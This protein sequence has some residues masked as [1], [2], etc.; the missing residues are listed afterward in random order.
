MIIN[1]EEVVHIVCENGSLKLDIGEDAA[2]VNTPASYNSW[3]TRLVIKRLDG[4]NSGPISALHVAGIFSEDGNYRLDIGTDAMKRDTPASFES[5]ATQL[6]IKRLDGPSSGPVSYGDLV[7][8]FDK[9]GNYRLDIGAV[10]DKAI[11]ASHDS[12]ATRLRIL[13]LPK[14][15]SQWMSQLPDETLLVNLAIP[16][17]H[18][19]AATRGWGK[20]LV[21]T[22]GKTQELPIG[23]Q[24]NMGIR[25]FDVRLATIDDKCVAIH[26]SGAVMRIIYGDAASVYRQSIMG[27]LDNNPGET[28]FICVKCEYGNTL[29]S[30]HLDSFLL[31]F[32]L[33]LNMTTSTTLAEVRGRAVFINDGLERSSSFP[34]GAFGYNSGDINE[35][36][37]YDLN[38]ADSEELEKK[39]NYVRAKLDQAKAEYASNSGVA[40]RNFYR[41]YASAVVAEAVWVGQYIETIADYEKWVVSSYFMAENE[42][43]HRVPGMVLLDYA[44]RSAVEYIFTNNFC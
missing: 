4:P 9:D 43:S 44:E 2:Q 28:V 34:E 1:Y 18:D 17:T 16:G 24:L 15:P 12:W 21:T 22:N 42:A 6:V 11:S 7:G 8:I 38:N 31:G 29:S 40:N 23:E 5:W 32:G 27:F 37:H 3:A 20:F 19:S 26:G 35:E 14:P 13:T 39:A 36:N 10:R 41:T 25:Y 30:E 33:Y